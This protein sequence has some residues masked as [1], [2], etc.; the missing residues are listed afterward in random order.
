M[1]GHI[2]RRIRNI[3]IVLFG[4]V[5][6]SGC[7]STPPNVNSQHASTSS[8]AGDSSEFAVPAAELIPELEQRVADN[9]KDF[10]AL[11]KLSSYY[12]QRQRET[13][14]DKYIAL[15]AKVAKS[16]LAVI[17]AERNQG[18][19]AALAQ[20]EL[21]SHQFATARD[22]AE[23]LIKLEP[24]KKYP[25]QILLDALIELGDYK[26]A[27]EVFALV[28][29]TSEP[30]IS[31]E[32]RAAKFELLHGNTASARQHIANALSFGMQQVPRSRESIAWCHWQMG[33][34]YFS[35]GNYPEAE[36]SFKEALATFPDYY[37][38]LAAMARVRSALGDLNGA[39]R[40]GEQAVQVISEPALLSL[41]GDLYKLAGRDAD[42]GRQYELTE[43]TALQEAAEGRL[44][45]R[46]LAL[47]YADH[48]LKPLDSFT[49]ASEDYKNRSD[50]YGADALAWAALKAN[51]L[52]EA[53]AAIK[54][55]LKLGTQD[56]R[57]FYHAG[58]IM[59]A[60]GNETAARD[61]FK[62]EAELNPQ[63]DP[64]QSRIA[65]DEIGR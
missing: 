10:V 5:L 25:R 18:A 9:P 42:A 61:Y 27:E 57:I 55:A 17:P 11:N 20:A 52:T 6:F 47:F 39:I 21:A 7:R 1:N 44:H 58:R 30:G 38:A 49:L 59:R 4:C 14:E 36:K 54:E 43:K 19:L 41:L 45:K 50:I 46:E 64:L 37:R 60:A 34:L 53:Q 33:E 35:T 24:D 28:K 48:D 16:S 31:S 62:R 26:R 13:G 32:T 63:F 65:K 51:K 12:L 3:A 40:Y 8:T 22:Y 29:K 23:Q 56:A 2:N 15:A